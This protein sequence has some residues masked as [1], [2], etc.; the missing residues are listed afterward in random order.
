[1]TTYF[2]GTGNLSRMDR[3]T[4]GPTGM[5][6][7]QLCYGTWR[8]GREVDGEVEIDRTSAHELLDTAWDL[9]IDFFDTA[10]TYGRPDRRSERW[11]GEWLA[12]RDRESVTVATK[13]GMDV[14]EG[15]RGHGLSRKHVRSQVERSLEALGTDYIDLY[16]VH[17][18]D[19]ATATETV[20]RTLDDLVREGKVHHLGASTMAAW[21][22]ARALRTSERL[23]A[24][25][26]L[27]TQP[28][29]DATFQNASRYEGFDLQDY[30]DVCADEELAVCPYSPLAGGFLTG[31]YARSGDGPG[32]GR[33]ERE[34][35][36][37]ER[38]YL[39]D[40]AWYVLDA[41]R[42]VADEV[43]ATP[44]Q[45]AIRWLVEQDRFSAVVPIVGARTPAQL[46]ENAGAADLS[47]ADEQV[48]RIA[49]ART[50]E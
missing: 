3:T 49:S 18:W 22:L 46:E 1:M 13:V 11:L 20:V 40:A 4:L 30:L 45:V 37:F 41:V 43:D 50:A 34:P 32:D 8:F 21:K 12:E 42:A 23:L 6:V 7:S 33:A 28:P 17:R 29:F 15:T 19:D 36:S 31:K 9:G 24:E 38:K 16:Y 5:E 14:G 39:S 48:E 26:F 10:N 25:P 35:D 27:V 44:A 47:L 2:R